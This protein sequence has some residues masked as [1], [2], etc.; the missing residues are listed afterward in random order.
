[1]K[2][3]ATKLSSLKTE[4]K[5]SKEILFSASAEV[6]RMFAEKYFPEVPVASTSEEEQEKHISNWEEEENDQ[7]EHGSSHGP[8]STQQESHEEVEESII[9]EKNRDSEVKK[10]FRKISLKIHPDKLVGLEDGYEK[11][12]KTMLYTKARQAWDDNDLI[13]L[14]EIAEEIDI[15]VP[16]IDAA[17]LKEA[18]KQIIAIKQEISHIESTIVW[19]WF[20][21]EDSVKKQEILEQL[22]AKMYEQRR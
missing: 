11:S 2:F 15:P 6:D 10:L 17:R 13:T 22:F 12:K 3:L 5:V 7:E 18:E 14:A 1:M 9:K 21:T 19:H 16:E 20:F 4:L 8:E